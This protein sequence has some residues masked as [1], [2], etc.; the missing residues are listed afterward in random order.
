MN[1]RAKGKAGELEAAKALTAVLECAV[2]R[3]AQYCGKAG[4]ADL[5]IEALPLLHTEI[6]RRRHPI[7]PDQSEAFLIQAQMDGG[8][9]KLPWCIHR[10]DQDTDWCVTLRLKRVYDLVDMLA[11]HKGWRA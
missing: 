7:T 8:P 3:N 6:K 10:V 5:Y 1:S 2:R 9:L 11:F 4:D